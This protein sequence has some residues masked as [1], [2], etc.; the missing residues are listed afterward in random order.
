LDL[1]TTERAIE[2][3]R[4]RNIS[5]KS[6]VSFKDHP[7]NLVPDITIAA[8]SGIST[9]GN[10]YLSLDLFIRY[11]LFSVEFFH[12]DDVQMFREIGVGC[13]LIGEALM[14]SADPKQ[15]IRQLLCER[16]D[17]TSTERQVLVKCCGITSKDDAEVAVQNGADLVGIIF[18]P[19]SARCVT[20]AQAKEIVIA[21]RKYGE[22]F[23]QSGEKDSGISTSEISIKLKQEME[24][25][26]SSSPTPKIWF[27]ELGKRIKKITRRQPLVVGVFQDQSPDEVTKT[28]LNYLFHLNIYIY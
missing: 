18:A 17:T 20:N 8:L 12:K 23:V 28:A 25:L 16:S 11:Q 27:S 21:V 26:L 10:V 15:T 2:V 24:T 1:H 5:F 3:A 14:K 19:K 4:Q 6:P 9:P 22:R 13:C 7:S